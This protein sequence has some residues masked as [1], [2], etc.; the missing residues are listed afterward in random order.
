MKLTAHI[1]RQFF[2]ANRVWSRK[3]CTRQCQTVQTNVK[4][5]AYK[6]PCLLH[7]EYAAADWDSSNRVDISDI[8]QL[9]NHAVR[10]IAGIK[11]R[12]GTENTKTRLG[13][14]LL[15]TKEGDT[16]NLVFWFEHHFLISESYNEI[17]NLQRLWQWDH[18]HVGFQL[19]SE[20][21][22]LSSTTV[23]SHKPSFKMNKLSPTVPM[24]G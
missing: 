16:S 12:D 7:L 24:L 19:P 10:F 17:M 18:R 5:V 6:T 1:H 11:E 15:Y 14:T 9:Q 3:C 22:T 21:T 4:L 8:E 23:L 20:L 2:T 13:L